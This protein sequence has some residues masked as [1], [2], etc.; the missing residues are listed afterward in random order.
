MDTNACRRILK[1]GRLV[2]AQRITARSAALTAVHRL[3]PIIGLLSGAGYA[4]K[5]REDKKKQ[6]AVTTKATNGREKTSWSVRQIP[7]FIEDRSVHGRSRCKCQSCP[8]SNS[9]T[10]KERP[11]AEWDSRTHSR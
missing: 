5:S 8:A 2:S 4:E 6:I 10:L 3:F 9:E 7:N 11:W 1:M